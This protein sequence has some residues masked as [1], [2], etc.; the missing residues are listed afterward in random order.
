MLPVVSPALAALALIAFIGSW[1]DLM[2]Q[3]MTLHD[4][5]VYTAPLALSSL[6]GIGRVPLGALFAGAALTMVPVIALFTLCARKLFRN[7]MMDSN[8]GL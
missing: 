8:S 4:M 6:V 2:S 7:L 5:Q 1:N 3:M